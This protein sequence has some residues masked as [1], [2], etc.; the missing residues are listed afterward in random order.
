MAPTTLMEGTSVRPRYRT[1]DE[2]GN[3]L[4]AGELGMVI[5][6]AGR[7]VIVSFSEG[8]TGIFAPSDLQAFPP[9]IGR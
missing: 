7:R 2:D 1:R 8:R 5:G 6:F 9:R 3:D 4:E